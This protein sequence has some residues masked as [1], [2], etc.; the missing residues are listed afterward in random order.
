MILDSNLVLEYQPSADANKRR[1]I[2]CGIFSLV[3]P[4][5]PKKRMLFSSSEFTLAGGLAPTQNGIDWFHNFGS[6]VLA[7]IML[8]GDFLCQISQ[9]RSTL[10]C[11][12]QKKRSLG[13]DVDII[14]PPIA[15]CTLS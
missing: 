4:H 3:N 15:A 10:A 7:F 12:S 11:K 6:S 8:T 1:P 9:A 13:P 2:G 5:G 14:S